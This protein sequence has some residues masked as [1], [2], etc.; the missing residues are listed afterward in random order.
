MKIKVLLILFISFY[1][2]ANGQDSD[3]DGILDS[4][5]NCPTEANTNQADSDGYYG[6]NIALGKTVTGNQYSSQYPPY[7]VADGLM[8]S[9]SGTNQGFWL[10][11]NLQ[12][13]GYVIIDLGA[14]ESVKKF[15]WVSHS[16][17]G[18]R[19]AKDYVIASKRENNDNFAI[20]TTGTM[21]QDALNTTKIYEYELQTPIEARYIRFNAATYHGSGSSLSEFQVIEWVDGDGI[22]DTCDNCPDDFNT[23]QTNSDND[24]F[25]DICDNCDDVANEDQLDSDAR[26]VNIVEGHP[27]WLSS[28]AAYSNEFTL[29]TLVDGNTL[30]QRPNYFLLADYRSGWV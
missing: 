5:D 8:Y 3:G 29:G 27:E 19:G 22:G 25:G 20:I 15:R 2:N 1:F 23:D 30:D 13:D 28:T 24:S 16:N 11:P 7:K 26:E 21:T 9:L 12:N 14:I 6:R 17:V 4:D 18:D 10:G